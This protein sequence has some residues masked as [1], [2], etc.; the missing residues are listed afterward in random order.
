MIDPVGIFLLRR[1]SCQTINFALP[2]GTTLSD[3]AVNTVT[4][5]WRS[6]LVDSEKTQEREPVKENA[7]K[8]QS[9]FKNHSAGGFI[10]FMILHIKIILCHILAQFETKSIPV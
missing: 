8:T 10:S 7:D 3:H 4:L 1:L 9:I 6:R 5:T 2:T